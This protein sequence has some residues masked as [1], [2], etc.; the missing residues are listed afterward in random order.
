MSSEPTPRG[1]WYH[2]E[3]LLFQFAVICA[4]IAVVLFGAATQVWDYPKPRMDF[5]QL[6]TWPSFFAALNWFASNQMKEIDDLIADGKTTR[7]ATIF[8]DV[9]MVAG[10]LWS[11]FIVYQFLARD[12]WGCFLQDKPICTQKAATP[13]EPA[14][15]VRQGAT[16]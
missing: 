7:R 11:I 9:L 1:P 16:P 15:T 6:A 13:P 5:G 8:L 4:A 12:V 3:Q 10:L 2:V 14:A